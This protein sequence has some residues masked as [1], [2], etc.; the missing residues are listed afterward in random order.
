MASLAHDGASVLFATSEDKAV[1]EVKALS[2]MAA[3]R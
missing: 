3:S 1:C 2:E